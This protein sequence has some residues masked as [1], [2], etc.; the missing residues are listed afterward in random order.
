MKKSIYDGYWMGTDDHSYAMSADD[1]NQKTGFVI[2][3]TDQDR[4]EALA[5][6]IYL[7]DL[8]WLTY[9]SIETRSVT[10]RENSFYPNSIWFYPN[11]RSYKIGRAHV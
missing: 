4:K 2:E 1:P 10:T 8:E 7:T 9:E 5:G 6:S 3:M 11:S